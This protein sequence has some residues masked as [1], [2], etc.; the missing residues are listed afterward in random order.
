MISNRVTEASVACCASAMI[1]VVRIENR[2]S[3][4]DACASDWNVPFHYDTVLLRLLTVVACGLH[5]TSFCLIQWLLM[6]QWISCLAQCP[7]S[8]WSITFSLPIFLTPSCTIMRSRPSPYSPPCNTSVSGPYHEICLN[9]QISSRKIIK[10]HAY[11]HIEN[12]RRRQNQ[13]PTGRI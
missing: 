8:A 4:Y 6:I 10:S 3:K 2:P 1:R 9:T 13:N 7:V 5:Q 11:Y 12:I